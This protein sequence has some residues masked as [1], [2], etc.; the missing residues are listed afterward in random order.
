MK[1]V[2]L[3]ARTGE[4]KNKH[5]AWRKESFGWLVWRWEDNM[6]K[7]VSKSVE[8]VVDLFQGSDQFQA[9]VNTLIKHQLP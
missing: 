1:W 6:K 9:S 8:C 3:V 5:K 7:D 4:M 2:R